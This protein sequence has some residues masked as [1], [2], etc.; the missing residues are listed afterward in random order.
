M[1]SNAESNSSA[2]SCPQAVDD[3]F[4]PAVD[5]CAR[6]FDFTLLF[7]ETILSILPSAIFLIL[8]A[9]RVATLFTRKSRVGG[10]ILRTVKLLVI[11]ALLAFSVAL[12]ALWAVGDASSSQRTRATVPAAALSMVDCFAFMALSFMEHG[13]SLGPPLLMD[14]Y[15]LISIILDVVRIRTM[16]VSEMSTTVS[17]LF[18]VAM[19]LKIGLLA[20]E[21][22]RKDRWLGPEIQQCGNEITGGIFTRT[23]FSWVNR[24]LWR[25]YST[26]LSVPS[27]QQVDPSLL[28]PAL[29]GK[30]RQPVEKLISGDERSLLVAV[31]WAL[32]RQLFAPIFPYLIVVASQLAQPY[33]IRTIL[34]YLGK[35]YDGTEYQNNI[36]YGLI[37]AYGLIY[38]CIAVATAWGQHLSYRFTVM[39][40]GVL[41]AT[42][43]RR[44][45]SMS[46]SVAEDA[47]ALSLMSTDVERIVM[48]MVHIHDCWST[49]VQVGIAMWI[50]YTEVGAIFIA[51]IVLAL[52]CTLLAVFLSS[53]AGA[54][55]ASWMKVLEKRVAI[56]S[57]LLGSVKSVKM[58]GWATRSTELIQQLRLAEILSA[59]KFRLML[60][61]VVT[62]SF[63][64][65]TLAPVLTFGVVA[66]QSHR[67]DGDTILGSNR[68]FTT[69]SLLALITQP[70]DLIFAFVPEILAGVACFQRI[71]DY[72]RQKPTSSTTEGSIPT[73]SHETLS[74]RSSGEGSNAEKWS[75]PSEQPLPVGEAIRL[76]D[77][78]FGWSKDAGPVLHSL[79]LQIPSGGLTM[80]IGPIASGKSTLLKGI[81][82]ETPLRRG[83]VQLAA[84]TC[85]RSTT[86]KT[87]N[88][89]PPPLHSPSSSSSI[90][91][92]DQKP[93][94][95]NETLRANVIGFQHFDAAWYAAVIR[96]CALEEDF[97]QFPEGDQIVIGSNGLSL[98]GGQKQRVAIA[99]AVYSKRDLVLFDDVFSGLDMH[100]QSHIIREVFG[101][102]GLLKAQGSTSVL[103]THAVHL[104]DHADF[105][106][107]L[108]ANG[109]VVENGPREVVTKKE[110]YLTRLGISQAEDD[111]AADKAQN[112][113]E[114][115]AFEPVAP[116]NDSLQRT[117]DEETQR[118]GDGSVYKY[119]FGT[120][121]WPKTFVFFALQTILVFCL[122]FPEIIL[123]WWGAANDAEPNKYN[124]KYLGI[125]TALEMMALVA[126]VLT[127][128]HVLLNLAVISGAKLHYTLLTTTLS[129]PITFFS[130]T[131]IGSITNRFSQDINLID[132]ELPFSLINFVTNGLTSL[133]QALM[134]IPASTWLLIGYPVLFGVLWVLQK[135][136][137]R[138]S[139][140][141]RFL[142]LDAKSPIYG[143]FLE[144]LGGLATIRAFGWQE[145]LIARADERL[146]AS[147]K[148]FYLL[149]SIQRWLNLVLDL[150]VAVVAIVLVAIAV[151]LRNTTSVGFTGV[152]LF[153]IMTLSAALKS[154]ISSWTL[155]ETSIGAVARVKR[156]EESTPNENS[157][158]DNETQL[159]PPADWPTTGVIVF[160][161]VT[162]TYKDD[163]DIENKPAISDLSLT[164][165]HGEKIGICGRSGSG[166]SSTLLALFHMI[167]YRGSIAIDG[168]DVARMSRETLRERLTAIPQDTVFLAGDVRLNCDPRNRSSDEQ[169]VEALR[170]AQLWDAIEAKGGLD[171]ELSDSS[172]SKGQQQ[173]FSLARALLD[174]S[175]IVAMD[176]SSSRLVLDLFTLNATANCVY[177]ITNVGRWAS[178]DAES[179]AH[180]MAVIRDKF[181]DATVI[182]IAHRL[183]TITDFDKVIV[184]DSG[185]VV[186][187][188]VPRD[189]LSQPSS[190]FRALYESSS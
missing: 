169:I 172:L 75:S 22:I 34:D 40:R 164:I 77:A 91:F 28:S 51:P 9:I 38:I 92:C 155:L 106:I 137:L 88:H 190:I 145:D 157:T 154:A 71:E 65:V 188:G 111:S 93:W 189:L 166:K 134:I 125:F 48:G 61:G 69:L 50:L 42:I 79:N 120:F 10:V 52:V 105:I 30:V 170:S 108:D 101:P 94:L 83:L 85:S 87:D 158:N 116:I 152:A 112:K 104:L 150:I 114:Q 39:L 99:R 168:L 23:L 57:S 147:Q 135:F 176:E 123:S 1:A 43:Y 26:A 110:D 151:S 148:P 181:R 49:I 124:G 122:K 89:T 70:L 80:V 86:H 63:L 18:T 133:A 78:A 95:A 8:G 16:W 46:L 139:R 161:K 156:F 113:T 103:V 53:F 179:E 159:E 146:D 27:L 183:D 178:L 187:V 141:L 37:A 100:T 7:E 6:T 142:D 56:T 107:G 149:Y 81:L 128:A 47:T 41:V 153:N 66:A 12:L 102:E 19:A 64:P 45:L 132:A 121:G 29:W 117:V 73:A 68:I 3:A 35:P 17:G 144:T 72:L 62:V 4:G 36:G 59:R 84:A 162:A 165:N 5:N 127:C 96:A 11:G 74:H 184:L 82:G 177:M 129:A 186:E 15:L 118:L 131:D 140:Q 54:F 98:S 55:Q 24:M 130:V 20:L 21:E 119:Y 185:R 171:A 136:Y 14:T 25:G 109:A 182:A 2:V 138:T 160:D 163:N 32:K 31:F 44:T 180:M 97:Q 60:L 167:N 58:L 115:A 13:K 67:G 90:A 126:L 143:Q 174:H 173:L 175:K 33:L 76:Q